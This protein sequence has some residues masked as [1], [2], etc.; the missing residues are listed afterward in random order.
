VA[1]AFIGEIRMM[2]FT[3]APKGWAQCNGQLLP[4]NQNQALFSLL[5]T[6]YGGNGQTNFALPDLRGRTPIHMGSGF[7]QGQRAGEEAH[8]LTIGELPAHSHFVQAS[9]GGPDASGGNSPAPTKT[10]SATS[11]GQ[12]Y[13]P[14]ANV[15][16]MSPSMIGNA[17]GSQPHANMMPS[18]VI[19]MCIALIGIF[20]PRN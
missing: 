2:A 6:M 16:N 13:G 8:T 18:M 7:T 9:S 5:G 17:G 12:L 1:E 14:Y 11:T 10:L 15:Q 3:F 20:P 19:G 4:I